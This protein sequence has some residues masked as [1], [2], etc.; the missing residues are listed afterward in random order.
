MEFEKSCVSLYE[1][2]RPTQLCTIRACY[3]RIIFFYKIRD[4][5]KKVDLR[6]LKNDRLTAI[7]SLKKNIFKNSLNFQMAKIK[8]RSTWPIFKIFTIFLFYIV[9]HYVEFKFAFDTTV[10]RLEMTAIWP[11]FVAQ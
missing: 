9:L 11:E 6:I 10:I 5:C 4:P 1:F 7:L 2:V 3:F 8:I